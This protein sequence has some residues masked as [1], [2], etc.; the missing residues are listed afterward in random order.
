MDIK[1][2][3]LLQSC[4]STIS[5][6]GGWPLRCWF[7]LL[8]LDYWN[9]LLVALI[10]HANRTAWLVFIGPEFSHVTLSVSAALDLKP[11]SLPSKPKMDQSIQPWFPIPSQLN[12]SL[13]K[14]QERLESRLFP[15]QAPR[16]W[17][18]LLLADHACFYLALE[19][20][21]IKHRKKSVGIFRLLTICTSLYRM[22]LLAYPHTEVEGCSTVSLAGRWVWLC[23]PVCS[24]S[25]SALYTRA[26]RRSRCCCSSAVHAVEWAEPDRN[27]LP[28]THTSITCDVLVYQ[29]PQHLLRCS[30]LVSVLSVS[31]LSCHVSSFLVHISFILLSAPLTASCLD[32]ILS[33]LPVIL[34]KCVS[35]MN[36]CMCKFMCSIT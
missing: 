15:I 22:P 27:A 29:D 13:A 8:R 34:D 18:Y 5:L 4:R 12:P 16:W 35:Q 31:Q 36:E 11:W 6:Q 17:N 10:A 3:I 20:T 26:E 32:C 33:H 28:R 24:L 9:T 21:Q 25:D 2:W 1:V 7:T 14:M 30:C 19:W 23:P